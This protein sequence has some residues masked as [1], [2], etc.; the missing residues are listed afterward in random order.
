M[1]K[2]FHKIQIIFNDL[3]LLVVV[4]IVF[5]IPTAVSPDKVNKSIL[6]IKEIIK[7]KISTY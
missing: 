1:L 3:L 6:K 4:V 5:Y 2:L 7:M